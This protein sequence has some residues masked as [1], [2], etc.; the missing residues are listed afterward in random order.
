MRLRLSAFF[1]V[2]VGLVGGAATATAEVETT[3]RDVQAAAVTGP[4]RSVFNNKCLE[5]LGFDNSNG[6]PVGMWDCVGGINQQWYW[7]G[8]QIRSAMNNKCLEILSFDNNNGA[9]VGM[10]D[11]W[12]GSNQQWYFDNGM[13]R[14]YMNNKCLEVLGYNNSNGARAGMWD[15]WGT[16]NQLWY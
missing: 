2:L 10:W 8:T 7:D 1:L 16:S 11:C 14:S 13:V 12:G 6:A 9:Y 4:A 15:C 3:A 5:I